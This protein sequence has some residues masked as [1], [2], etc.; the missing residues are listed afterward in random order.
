MKVVSWN[1]NGLRACGKKGF[2]DWLQASGAEIVGI[3]EVRAHPD[4]LPLELRQIDGWH[5]HF[6]TSSRPG[7]SGVGLYS[8]HAPFEVATTLEHEPF[9]AEG[10]L[11]IARIGRL[12]VVNGYF[13]NGNGKE[14]DN[15]RIPYKLAFY[16]RLFERLE[17][18]KAAGEPVLVMGDFNTAHREI[19]LARPKQNEETSGF[20]P[21]EREEFDRW[22]RAGW[23]DTFRAFHL[24]PGHYSWWSARFGAREKNIGWRI[25]YVLA[26]PGAMAHVR[27]A[28]IWP[29]VR[30]SDHCP[31]GVEID[32]AVMG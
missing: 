13:P 18:L 24:E 3:Q 8:R 22:I 10:R 27:D 26:S 17:P 32:G 19:D 6:V 15:S 4:Q 12:T 30:G 1:V 23:V 16:Q 25:D 20:R 7:Y 28:F 5:T 21:E 14:R 11:Q 29:E 2:G 9:D 31:V